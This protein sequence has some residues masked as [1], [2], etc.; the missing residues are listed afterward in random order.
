VVARAG[1]LVAAL[2]LFALAILGWIIPVM[3]GIPFWIMGF[4]VL[5]MVSRRIAHWINR[6]ERRLPRR[7]RLLLRPGQRRKLKARG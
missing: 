7:V 5:G 1:L 3:P 2:A 4:Q 6:Q